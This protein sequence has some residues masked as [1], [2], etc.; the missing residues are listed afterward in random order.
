MGAMKPFIETYCGYTFQP[1]T[2]KC[3][4]IKIVDVAHA[5]SNQGRFTGHT[6]FFYSVAEHSVRVAELVKQLGGDTRTQ[7]W[8]LLHD[9]SEAYL[10]DV[11]SPLKR[12]P[13]FA[14]YRRA[15]KTLMVAVCKRFGLPK[16]RPTIVY[17]ADAML[18]A[19]E[20]RDLMHGDRPYWKKL[21]EVPIKERIRPWS[22][23]VARYEF[24]KT[25]EAL[26]GV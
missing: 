26:G 22:S 4:D 13:G 19:T 8:G 5:L 2:P 11:P 25:F 24:L 16:L 15:E 17:R 14:A 3:Q 7:L 10:V 18:L 20:V 23:Y 1:L 6:R 9:S 12:S 21:I